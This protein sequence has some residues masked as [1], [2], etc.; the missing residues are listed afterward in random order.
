MSISSGRRSS[1]PVEQGKKQK[2]RP[3]SAAWKPRKGKGREHDW[4]KKGDFL[5]KRIRGFASFPVKKSC[6][7]PKERR[8]R[9]APT[10]G[11]RSMS[12]GEGMFPGRGPCDGISS[13][14]LRLE[15]ASPLQ[16]PA[17]QRDGRWRWKKTRG[18]TG[19][20]PYPSTWV[21]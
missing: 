10:K 9:A 2:P 18:V 13:R 12:W 3:S 5:R 7:Y 14:K 6:R 4:K 11:S 21:G 19:V 20:T 16:S 8:G 17:A 15:T 1:Q